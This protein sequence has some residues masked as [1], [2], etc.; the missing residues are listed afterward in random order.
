MLQLI[1]IK[2]GTDLHA[3]VV[4]QNETG[5]RAHVRGYNCHPKQ[6]WTINKLRTNHR[7]K[8]RNKQARRWSDCICIQSVTRCSK[9]TN[10]NLRSHCATNAPQLRSES[11]CV[12]VV[13]C[14]VRSIAAGHA[15]FVLATCPYFMNMHRTMRV[16]C[17]ISAMVRK[18]AAG[19]AQ[20]MLA[21]CPYFMNMHRTMRVSCC[22]TATVRKSVPA[23]TRTALY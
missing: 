22:I 3:A 1:R 12:W 5:I 10:V 4:M 16:S 20:L 11:F 15:Q 17:C 21:T 18:F 6:P 13:C 2:A 23:S 14:A 9:P 7:F 8:L 19:H